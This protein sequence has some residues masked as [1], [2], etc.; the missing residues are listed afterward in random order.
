MAKNEKTYRV[1]RAS[2]EDRL[3]A[4]ISIRVKRPKGLRI[5]KKVLQQAIDYKLDHPNFSDPRGF[6]LRII[7]W[8]NPTRDASKT[9]PENGRPL[10]APRS[11]GPDK[12]RWRTLRGPLRA[13][14]KRITRNKI[15][16]IRKTK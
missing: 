14:S 4:E 6:K 15:P 13:A 9:N 5:T 11:Y 7:S 12:E 2:S 16:Q 8:T 10:N 1:R 3:L